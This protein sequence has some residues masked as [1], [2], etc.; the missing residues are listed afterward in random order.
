MRLLTNI[1]LQKPMSEESMWTLVEQALTPLRI[2]LVD[3]D[4]DGP[5]AKLTRYR[6]APGVTTWIL[7]LDLPLKTRSSL[8]DI[9]WIGGDDDTGMVA[10]NQIPASIARD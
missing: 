3:K 8:D 9:P 7:A 6:A 4:K 2:S 1:L 10:D 5:R